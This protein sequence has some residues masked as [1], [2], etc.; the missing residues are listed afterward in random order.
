MTSVASSNAQPLVSVIVPLYNSGRTLEK[1]L[2]AI[3]SQS[4]RN[5]EVLLIDSSSTD[6]TRDISLKW[7]T[8]FPERFRYYNIQKKLQAA[9]RNFGAKVAHGE[10]LLTLDSDMYYSNTLVEESTKK[11][12]K[13]YDAVGIPVKDIP[14]SRGYLA[15]CVFYSLHWQGSKTEQ[16]PNFYKRSVYLALGGQDETIPYVEDKDFAL[17]FRSAG[18]KLI[19][20]NSIG[21]HD[22][23]VNLR[24]MVYKSS[25]FA[26]GEKVLAKKWSKQIVPVVNRTSIFYSLFQSMRK[27]VYYA[28]GVFLVFFIRLLAKFVSK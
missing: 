12:A 7:C 5:I 24:W 23:S 22:Q 11:V 27:N 28:P 6:S 19:P 16:F 2:D 20:I 18:Y 17:K 26:I 14:P 13:G 10:W 9:K 8:R 4:Y 3:N 15:K 1:C 25:L 21:L